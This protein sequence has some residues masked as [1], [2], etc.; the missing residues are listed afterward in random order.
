LRSTVFL[1]MPLTLPEQIKQQIKQARGIVIALPS[2]PGIDAIAAALVLR[3]SLADSSKRIDIVCDAFTAPEKLNFFPDLSAIKSELNGLRKT[4]LEIDKAKYPV[5]DI[6]YTVRDNDLQILLSPKADSIPAEAI[7]IKPMAYSY[8]LILTLTT[9]EPSLLGSLYQK[10]RAFFDETPII[11]I[12]HRPDNEQYGQINWIELTASSVSEMIF[13]HFAGKNLDKASATALMA[14]IMEETH[15]FRS[16]QLKPKTLQVVSQLLE[17][18]A[19]HETVINK[20]YR[21]KTVHLLKLWGHILTHLQVDREISLVWSLLPQSVFASTG[22]D[23]SH[24]RDLMN[25]VLS[26]TPE[27]KTVL[28]FLEQKDGV[29][30]QAT[31]TP[32]LHAKELIKNWNASG[33]EV[34]AQAH[35]KGKNLAQC[36]I[37]VLAVIKDRLRTTL[38]T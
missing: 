33:S 6:S 22:T 23:E 13:E 19:D 35:L 11:N 12:D 7:R 14:G 10:H 25:E 15:S 20:L 27:A 28:L 36:E 16:R 9:V 2:Q 34:T 26:H 31:T 4:M 29:L 37:E 38:K 30:L 1:F 3:R 24:V 21:T 5:E 17:L 18:G 32:P 8:D